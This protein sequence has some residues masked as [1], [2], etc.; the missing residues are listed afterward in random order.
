VSLVGIVASVLVFSVGFSLITEI[1]DLVGL[2]RYGRSWA[3]ITAP[4]SMIGDDY[5]YFA[6]L[7]ELHKRFLNS[8]GNHRLQVRDF[9]VATK[10][11]IAGMLWNLPAYALGYAVSDR[12]LAVMAVRIANRGILAASS[13]AFVMSFMPATGSKT[14]VIVAMGTFVAYFLTYPGPTSPGFRNSILANVRNR[15]HTFDSS[16]SN[17]L[18]RAMFCE[19]SAPIMIITLLC[20]AQAAEA[21]TLL[22]LGLTTVGIVALAFTY[23]PALLP[24]T[25]FSVVAYVSSASYVIAF[26]TTVG[27]V[28][29][30][31]LYRTS[32]LRDPVSRAFFAPPQ[33]DWS[34]VRRRGNTLEVVAVVSTT[35]AIT[36]ALYKWVPGSG[37]LVQLLI[38]LSA[39]VVFAPLNGVHIGRVWTRG[40]APVYYLTLLTAILAV[41]IAVWPSEF[42]VAAALL[43]AVSGLVVL[44]SY[45]RGQTY[46]IGTSHRL[47]RVA[48]EVLCERARARE[49]RRVVTDSLDVAQAVLLYTSDFCDLVNFSVQCNDLNTHVRRLVAG[50]REAGMSKGEVVRIMTLEVTYG[51]W[52][53]RRPIERDSAWSRLAFAH[54][55]QFWATNR[56]YNLELIVKGYVQLDGGWTAKYQELVSE[57]WDFGTQGEPS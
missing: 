32:V 52:L 18:T 49:S 20:G 39:F 23:L 40:S 25:L 1:P 19:T 21:P 7:S 36:W 31:I 24:A 50:L 56:E 10:W 45:E 2:R 51:D 26:V 47:P 35:S 13:I 12:R 28:I 4:P 42:V 5:H 57:A 15:R 29:W 46:H 22:W 54:S 37:V 9:A 3:P 16:A 27:V 38:C 44:T 6:L 11:Q 55:L 33:I 34:E 17:D 8:L 53:P 14:A 41:A 30:L 43:V 48:A